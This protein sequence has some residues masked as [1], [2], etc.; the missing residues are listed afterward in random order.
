MLFV[1]LC[2]IGARALENGVVTVQ[3]ATVGDAPWSQAID[4]NYGAAGI[5]VP[6]EENISIVGVLLEGLAN[7]V[8]WVNGVVDITAL[9]K[10]RDHGE[11]R[12]FCDW[13][14]QLGA[15]ELGGYVDLITLK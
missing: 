12:N 10:L 11:M 7:E 14:G 5:Y 2:V 3:S 15:G 8:G 4:Y 13:S 1:W 9:R 6:P